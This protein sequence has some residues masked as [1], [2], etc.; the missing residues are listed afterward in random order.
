[1]INPTKELPEAKLGLNR[2]KM[3]AAIIVTVEA[4]ILCD[5]HFT[6]FYC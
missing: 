5:D 6:S 3:K 2:E 4:V 1:M